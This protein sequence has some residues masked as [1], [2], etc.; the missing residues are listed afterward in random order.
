ML[1]V[2]V[3]KAPITVAQPDPDERLVMVT[4]VD[5]IFKDGV[6]K[7]PVP[8]LPAVKVMVVVFPVAIVAP[9]RLYVTLY[10]P[11]GNDDDLSVI[12]AADA[13]QNGLL[14]EAAAVNA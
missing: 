3:L 4:V 9:D 7:V 6:E 13:L 8:G 10:V 11:E 14:F 12:V 2:V 5:P 1:T